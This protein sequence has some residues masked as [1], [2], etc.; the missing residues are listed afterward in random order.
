MVVLSFPTLN[1]C[2]SSEKIA[3]DIL[4]TLTISKEMKNNMNIQN[5]AIVHQ[6]YNLK[7]DSPQEYKTKEL[8]SIRTFFRNSSTIRFHLI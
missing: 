5:G 2:L 6:W 7:N 1:F 3:G 4:I 8:I